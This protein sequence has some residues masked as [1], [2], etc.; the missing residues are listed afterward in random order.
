MKLKAQNVIEV[1]TMVALVAVVVVTAFM[2]MQGNNSNIAKL[3][4]INTGKATSSSPAK[5]PVTKPITTPKTPSTTDTETA[6][7]LSSILAYNNKTELAVKLASLTLNDV[8]VVKTE[9][10]ETIFELADKLINEY[11]LP[12]SPFNGEQAIDDDAK[13]RLMDI[14]V[15]TNDI[16][17]QKDTTSVT[18]NS[19]ISLLKQILKV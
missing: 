15:K 11:N 1:I 3:S 10:N 2:F 12:V 16:L 13:S 9:N 14:A 4:S 5:A 18:F 17:T 6:G 8:L 7:A 19:Y